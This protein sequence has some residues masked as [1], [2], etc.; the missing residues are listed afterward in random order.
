VRE[1]G[2]DEMGLSLERDIKASHDRCR[3]GFAADAMT[4]TVAFESLV[5]IKEG[6][7]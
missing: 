2:K 3:E 6:G 7:K 5:D 1:I 4:G